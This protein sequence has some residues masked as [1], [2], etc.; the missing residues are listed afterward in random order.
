M[1]API[2]PFYLM[3]VHPSGPSSIHPSQSISERTPEQM[4]MSAC[5]KISVLTC[6]AV[7]WTSLGSDPA[8]VSLRFSLPAE[9]SVLT[10]QRAKASE[11]GLA[12]PAPEK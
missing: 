10:G 9:S 7:R 2:Q 6:W 1:P 3:S 4:F 5:V 11:E 12:S 8:D